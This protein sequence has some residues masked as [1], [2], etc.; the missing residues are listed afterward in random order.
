MKKL[1]SSKLNSNLSKDNK[2][3]ITVGQIIVL[4]KI[5]K[6]DRKGKEKLEIGESQLT[7]VEYTHM[8]AGAGKMGKKGAG[9]AATPVDL[10]ASRKETANPEVDEEMAQKDVYRPAVAG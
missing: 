5:G 10:K 8:G 9:K 3:N 1:K 2:T 7:W 6:T 4:I